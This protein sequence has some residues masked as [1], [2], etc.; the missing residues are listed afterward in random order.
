M[1]LL[2]IVLCAPI[3]RAADAAIDTDGDGLSDADELRLGTDPNRSDTDGD[4][5]PDGLELRN[6]YNPR[7]PR[8]VKLEKRIIIDRAAQQFTNY[9][10]AYRLGEYRVSTGKPR[11][12]T[13]KGTYAIAAKRPRAWSSNAR[14]WMPWWLNFTG[15]GA[16]TGRY[17]IH[18][19]PEWASG[20]KEGADHL[21]KPVS[22][23]CVRLGVGP[24]KMVYDWAEIGTKVVV[25]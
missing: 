8:P 2:S 22:G 24:A 15:K 21:G 13:P 19:L 17:A 11:T 3:A 7:D 1:I 9:V 20:K 18:E 14:L 6:A 23:G 5:Y 12:P 4:G 16:P 25:Q 10:G